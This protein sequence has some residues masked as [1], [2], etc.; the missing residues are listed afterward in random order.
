MDMLLPKLVL[1]PGMDGSGELFRDF[2]ELLPKELA[3]EAVRYPPDIALGYAALMKYVRAAVPEDKP[4]V[5]VAESFSVPLAILL[6]ATQPRN[7]EGLVLCSGFATSPVRGW[8]RS[9]GLWIL[10]AFFYLERLLGHVSLP[11]FAVR[12]LLLSK[13]ALPGMVEALRVQVSWLKPRVIAKRMRAALTCDV[14]EALAKVSVPVLYVQG[15]QEALVSPECL[16]EMQML[17]PGKTVA[18]FGP[19]MILQ[20]QAEVSAEAVGQ[21]VRELNISATVEAA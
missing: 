8:M 14:R 15:T 3:S 2:Q 19:H 20:R 18:I 6:A 4:F 5:L 10:P 21:F 17:K 12:W 9:V 16:R 7:L 11:G 13:D 1:L